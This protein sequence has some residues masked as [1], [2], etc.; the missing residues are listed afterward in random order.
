VN[1][2]NRPIRSTHDRHRR[3]HRLGRRFRRGLSLVEVMIT[4][5]IAG[6]LLVA[7]GMAWV[8]STNAVEINDRTARNLQA[9][10]VSM[11]Q[12]TNEIRRCQAV[13]VASDHVDLITFDAHQYTYQYVAAAKQLQFVNKDVTPNVTHVLAYNVTGCTFACDTAPNPLTQVTCVVHVSIQMTVNPGNAPFTLCGSA[14]P[15]VNINY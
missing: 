3:H 11:L 4:T 8:A 13:N 15:R 5:A 10:S 7:T 14:A 1:T 6:T 2:M 9:G 12:M